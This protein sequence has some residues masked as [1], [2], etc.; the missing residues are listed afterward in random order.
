VDYS[1]Q[2]HSPFFCPCHD[3]FF[4]LDGAAQKGPSPRGLDALPIKTQG[5][6]VLVEFHRYVLNKKQ[7]VE[8]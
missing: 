4:S 3:S 8:S 2:K 5:E 1:G 6:R 7:Q